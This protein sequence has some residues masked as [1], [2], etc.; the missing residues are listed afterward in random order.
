MRKIGE[1]HYLSTLPLTY[2][3]QSGVVASDF[4]LVRSGLT[5]LSDL[6]VRGELDAGPISI[7]HYLRYRHKFDRIP[8]L[9]VSSW[10][11]A[12]YGVLFSSTPIG[13]PEG[14]AI[15][16]PSKNAGSVYLLRSLMKEMY[17][18]EPTCIE[19]TGPLS[20]LL[21]NPGATMLYED[22]ALLASQ[23]VG[24]DVEVWDMGDAWWQFTN[25]PLIYMLWVSQKGLPESERQQI[26]DTL[27][28]AKSAAIAVRPHIA[29][30]AQARTGLP[31][32]TI[33][34]FLA[35]F[36]YDFT[37]AHEESLELLT[38]TIMRLDELKA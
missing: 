21:V 37:P 36:N 16:V 35:R 8:N 34:G 10:G 11:R 9:A 7:I 4:R 14:Q 18:V 27:A 23:K 15:A 1:I 17:G 30:E 3:L 24:R 20:D 26:T 13:H 12:S 22:D 25:T 32:A 2:P 5:E 28:Q 38:Q 19:Q 6:L 33:E 29:A 31:A